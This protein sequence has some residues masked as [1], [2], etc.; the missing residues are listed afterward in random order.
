MLDNDIERELLRDAVDPEGD[1]SIAVNMEMGHQ[2]QRRISSN[3]NNANGTAINAIKSINR[4]CGANATG[5]QS[6]RIS[7]NRAATGQCKGCGQTWTSTH[8]QV[9]PAQGKKR[10]HCGL[11]NHFAKVCRKKLN[12]TRNSRQDTC[13]I[14]EENFEIK[15]QVVNPEN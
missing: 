13:I 8:R 3:N 12:N 7:F 4:F 10:S 11:L 1:L 14:N 15:E 2:N 5:N 9:C 6:G